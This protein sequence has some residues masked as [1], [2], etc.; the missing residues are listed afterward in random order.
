MEKNRKVETRRR[1][2]EYDCDIKSGI[3]HIGFTL[4]AF[5]YYLRLACVTYNK[6]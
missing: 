3:K 5:K 1:D 2:F 4:K 6:R